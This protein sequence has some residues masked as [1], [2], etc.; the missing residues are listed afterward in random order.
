MTISALPAP[1][2]KSGRPTKLLSMPPKV[3]ASL[4]AMV[5]DG[6]PYSTACQAAGVAERT[7]KEWMRKGRAD[8][9][10]E[11]YKSFAMSIEKAFADWQIDRVKIIAASSD[12]RMHQWLL[13]RRNTKE[14]GDPRRGDVNVQVNLSAIMESPDWQRLRDDLVRS[15][16][17]FPEA[18]ETALRVMAGDIVNG[19]VI[20]EAEIREIESS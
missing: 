8:D 16:A 2:G 14:W 9:A 19:E 12:P 5:A 6:V 10:R 4:I 3:R 20:E 11:P 15:L 13:E 17:A 7:F 18:L 1:R